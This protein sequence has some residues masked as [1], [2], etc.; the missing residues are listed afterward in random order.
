M[1]KRAKLWATILEVLTVSY[2]QPNGYPTNYC[3]ICDNI[4]HAYNLRMISF[5]EAVSLSSELRE[6]FLPDYPTIYWWTI[7]E[8]E[9]GLKSEAYQQRATAIGL[10]IAI[11]S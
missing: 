5:H 6:V 4:S 1:K 8:R 11:N 9:A 2:N 10:L 7:S 3:G